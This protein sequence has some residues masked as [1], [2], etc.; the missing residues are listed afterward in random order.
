M[1][2]QGTMLWL[3]Q[4]WPRVG[5]VDKVMLAV[6]FPSSPLLY[7]PSDL[8]C[9]PSNLLFAAP[10]PPKGHVAPIPMAGTDTAPPQLYPDPTALGS[11]I[12]CHPLTPYLPQPQAGRSL[13][14]APWID[15][16][17]GQSSKW[18]ERRDCCW[19]FGSPPLGEGEQAF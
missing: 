5:L 15:G 12:C 17:R 10:L 14:A 4:C 7:V 6:C 3:P 2:K 19:W 11:I 18:G 13:A 1:S 9:I 16:H 8:L